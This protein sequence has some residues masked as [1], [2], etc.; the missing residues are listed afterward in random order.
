[1]IKKI[2]EKICNGSGILPYLLKYIIGKLDN[3]FNF[4][5]TLLVMTNSSDRPNYAY[6]IYHAA[7]LAKKLGHN[8]ISIVEFGVAGGNGIVFLEKFSKKVENE[9]KK[10]VRRLYDK[11]LIQQLW[12]LM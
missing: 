9:L 8:S 1:M 2:L 6:C 11:Q 5:S 10:H 3:I 7:I 12:L 4:S